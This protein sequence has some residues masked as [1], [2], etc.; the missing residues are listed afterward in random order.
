M[1]APIEASIRKKLSTEYKPLHMT[2]ENESYK[3]NVPQGSETHF[4]VEIVSELFKNQMLVK[5]HQMIYATLKDEMQTGVHALS[6]KTMTP[7]KWEAKGK[8]INHTSPN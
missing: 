6:L 5:Q 4:K 8:K 2:I 7:E 1:S 3:H